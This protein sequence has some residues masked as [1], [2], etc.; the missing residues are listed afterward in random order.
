MEKYYFISQIMITHPPPKCPWFS[1]YLGTRYLSRYL[2]K[3]FAFGWN[4]AFMA[5]LTSSS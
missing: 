4:G 3:S 2:H 1:L 5:V